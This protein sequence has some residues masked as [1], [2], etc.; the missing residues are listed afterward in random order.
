MSMSSYTGRAPAFTIP[1]SM[2]ALA[3]LVEGLDRVE[4]SGPDGM[5]EEDTVHCFPH[6]LFPSEKKM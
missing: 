1:M 2:P 3:V 4:E 5:V 6:K